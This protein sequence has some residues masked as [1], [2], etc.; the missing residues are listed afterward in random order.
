[1]IDGNAGISIDVYSEVP[2]IDPYVPV[3][4]IDVEVVLRFVLISVFRV[5]VRGL[6][7]Q[8]EHHEKGD[9]CKF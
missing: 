7:N 5:L 1:M 4:F 9:N 8:E 6:Y 3:E 2:H